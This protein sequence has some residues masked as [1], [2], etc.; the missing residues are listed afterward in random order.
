[1]EV[2]IIRD[3]LQPYHNSTISVHLV[4]LI[5]CIYVLGFLFLEIKLLIISSISSLTHF[6]HNSHNGKITGINDFC[7]DFER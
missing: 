1:M 7:D 2:N 6:H 4:I 5:Y 3:K